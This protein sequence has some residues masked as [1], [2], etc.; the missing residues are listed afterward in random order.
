MIVL[1]YEKE[2]TLKTPLSFE[3]RYSCTKFFFVFLDKD[4][5]ESAQKDIT[6]MQES[7]TSMRKEITGKFDTVFMRLLALEKKQADASGRQLI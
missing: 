5:L 4:A 7:I 3:E 6:S 2:H 1:H